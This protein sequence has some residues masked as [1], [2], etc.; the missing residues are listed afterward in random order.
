MQM[1]APC[2]PELMAHVKATSP[3]VFVVGQAAPCSGFYRVIHDEH[4]PDHLVCV[5][6][7]DV[8]PACRKCTARV[9]FQLWIEAAYVTQDWDLSGPDLSF[10]L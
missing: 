10:V 9:R 1:C 4:R 5:V 7:G 3:S 6:K 2:A 8:F